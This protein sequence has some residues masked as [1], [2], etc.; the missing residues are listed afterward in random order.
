[1]LKNLTFLVSLIYASHS[2]A[3]YAPVKVGGQTDT[4]GSQFQNLEFPNSQVSRTGPTSFYIDNGNDNL[5]RNAGGES[6]VL[7]SGWSMSSTGTAV[8]SITT[9]NSSEPMLGKKHLS[10]N[11]N[12]GASGGTCTFYQDVPTNSAFDGL[13]KGG[14]LA[15]LGALGAKFSVFK[16]INGVNVQEIK[17]VYD[18]TGMVGAAK[19][20]PYSFQTTLGSV[21]TGIAY[22]ITAVPVG[23]VNVWSDANFVGKADLRAVVAGANSQYVR[24]SKAGTYGAT[25]SQS[26]VSGLAQEESK[27]DSGLITMNLATGIGTANKRV[28]LNISASTSAAS[29]SPCFI[30]LAKNGVT[31]RGDTSY[32][33]NGYETAISR[34][35]ILEA[36]ETFSIQVYNQ[37]YQLS[38]EFTA[39][40]SVSSSSYSA[41]S[42]NTGWLPCTFA[43]NVWQ[44]LGIISHTLLCKKQGGDLLITGRINTGTTSAVVAQIPLPLWN[45]IQLVAAGSSRL[46]TPYHFSGRLARNAFSQNDY[47]VLGV[48]SQAFLNVSVFNNASYYPHIAANGNQ[49]ATSSDVLWLEQVR[50]PIEGWDDTEFI[51]ASI[52]ETPTTQGSS[53][54]DIQSVYFGGGANCGTDCSSGNCTICF[55]VGN[56]IT[57]VTAASGNGDF[58]L[59]GIDGL[60]YNC[61]GTHYSTLSNI[62]GPMLHNRAASTSTY[63]RVQGGTGAGGA[64]NRAGLASITCIGI[65]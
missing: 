3:A 39:I 59:N 34:N 49:I 9:V 43:T 1:M 53:G 50:I 48:S 19:W 8:A 4:S 12:S 63:A 35:F 54:T 58:N 30:Y 52:K 25:S 6:S 29:A 16:R 42:A 40:E 55:Q 37:C 60:K 51:V 61:N 13:V 62:I 65:P 5:L 24:L 15:G 14:A 21:S 32:P 56:K 44:G 11:C 22:V 10:F 20:Y 18:T 2:I 33:G 26:T 31:T 36:G 45:G 46:N 47:S 27:G 64:Q 57:S 38:S 28:S 7:G 17:G 41:K 23:S